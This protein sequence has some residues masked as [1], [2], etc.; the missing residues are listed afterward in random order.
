MDDILSFHATNEQACPVRKRDDFSADTENDSS[1]ASR[2]KARRT[3]TISSA[4]S[5]ASPPAA[6]SDPAEA[7]TASTVSAL[8]PPWSSDLPT[9]IG[10][11]PHTQDG[12][13]DVS[14]VATLQEDLTDLYHRQSHDGIF[15]TGQRLYNYYWPNK[16]TTVTQTVRR[17]DLCESNKTHPHD[18]QLKELPVTPSLP[19]HYFDH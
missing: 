16:M 11:L 9:S 5:Q 10:L 4:S 6:I 17:C 7:T 1:I 15:A 19:D 13:V 2:V 12:K 3:S 8:T 14:D 18:R